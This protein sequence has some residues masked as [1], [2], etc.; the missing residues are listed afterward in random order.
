[1]GKFV[2]FKFLT[3]KINDFYGPH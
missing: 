3:H 2:N 1:M